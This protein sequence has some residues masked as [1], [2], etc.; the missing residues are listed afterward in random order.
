MT[1]SRFTSQWPKRDT[2]DSDIQEQYIASLTGR[3]KK[4]KG[5]PHAGD[6]DGLQGNISTSD[7][8]NEPATPSFPGK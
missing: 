8:P 4:V 7:C 5:Y 6:L 3:V 2:P 1:V